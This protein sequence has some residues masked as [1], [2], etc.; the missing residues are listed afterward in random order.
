MFGAV[1][2][3]R[4]VLIYNNLSLI[5]IHIFRKQE[6]SLASCTVNSVSTLLHTAAV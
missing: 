2:L 5:E 6:D 1:D 4:T 3:F